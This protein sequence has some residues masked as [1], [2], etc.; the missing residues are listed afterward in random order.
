VGYCSAE[1]GGVRAEDL[2]KVRELRG[3][4]A[5]VGVGESRLVFGTWA[6]TPCGLEVY[7]VCDKG[8]VWRECDVGASGTDDGIVVMGCAVL[9]GNAAFSE[10]RDG[11]GDV[12][13]VGLSDGFQ[14]ARAGS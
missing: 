4:D 11:R 13:G 5:K 10:M 8:E 1:A 6:G 2:E 12:A 3:S 9:E 14:V 7:P